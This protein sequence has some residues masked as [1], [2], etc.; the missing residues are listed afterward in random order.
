MAELQQP[1]QKGTHSVRDLRRPGV[2]I[3]KDRERETRISL[4]N[5]RYSASDTTR[6]VRMIHYRN[7][8][9]IAVTIVLHGSSKNSEI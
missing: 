2:H 8:V 9:F 3:G 6:I 7:I 1:L 5:T 4:C